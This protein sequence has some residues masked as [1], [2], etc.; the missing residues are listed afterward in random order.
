MSHLGES[1]TGQGRFAEAEP[2]RVPRGPRP[3]GLRVPHTDAKQKREAIERI[4]ALYDGRWGKPEKCP[5]SGGPS[6]RP[7][8]ESA[9]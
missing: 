1:L 9:E 2:T 6:V 8:E 5:P 7:I 3:R 4:V